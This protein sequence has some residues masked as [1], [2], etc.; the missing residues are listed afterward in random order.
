[1][2]SKPWLLRAG[3]SGQQE[4]LEHWTKTGEGV[5]H[6]WEEDHVF[7][8]GFANDFVAVDRWGG[9]SCWFADASEFASFMQLKMV[10]CIGSDG[11]D[12]VFRLGVAP[13][14]M[15]Y[16]QMVPKFILSSATCLSSSQ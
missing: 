4:R 7:V 12:N 14:K 11:L 10:I 5:N 15:Y 6:D 3:F 1:V 2:G 16:F 8:L 13:V 9:G